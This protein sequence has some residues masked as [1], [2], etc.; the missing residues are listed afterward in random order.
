MTKKLTPKQERF[1]LNLFKGLSQREAYIQAGYSSNQLPATLDRHA[2]DLASAGNVLARLQELQEETKNVAIADKDEAGAVATEILRSRFADFDLENPTKEQL[3]SAAVR[4]VVKTVH[5]GKDGESTVSYKL[6][7]ESPLAAIDRLAEI[8]NWKKNILFQDNRTINVLV[9]G[10]GA[11]D[12]FNELLA[13]KR[14]TEIKEGE[15]DA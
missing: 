2:F 9:Q 4:E 11:K 14:P 13:G 5:Y 6:K 12:R 3:K 8:Y 7:L 15:N 10:D 1:A